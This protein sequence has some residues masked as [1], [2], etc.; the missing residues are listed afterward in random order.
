MP[1]LVQVPLLKVTI[2]NVPIDQTTNKL[3]AYRQVVG[4]G[5]RLKIA[6]QQ[7]LRGITED[8][9]N[10]L[11]DPEKPALER[12]QAYA[13]RG[14]V[15]GAAESFFANAQRL[16]VLLALSDVAHDRQQIF[17]IEA[18]VPDI[19]FDGETTAIPASTRALQLEAAGRPQSI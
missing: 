13:D 4:M 10:S 1:L 2:G 9:A 16:L 7:F 18:D 15:E 5:E 12:D 14:E 11:V 17:P 8:I 19:D 6:G 3:T